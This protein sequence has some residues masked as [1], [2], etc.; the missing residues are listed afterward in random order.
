MPI[1]Q[2]IPRCQ[3]V[4]TNG[5]RCGSPSLANRV[6]CYYHFKASCPPPVSCEIT[7]VETADGIQIAIGN[8]LQA[9]DNDRIDIKKAVAMLYGLQTASSNLKRTNPQPAWDEVETEMPSFEQEVWHKNIATTRAEALLEHDI[10]QRIKDDRQRRKQQK[11]DDAFAASLTPDD[12]DRMAYS[13]TGNAAALTDLDSKKEKRK[14][15]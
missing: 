2:H 1:P 6:F 14:V 8:V 10:Q 4:R 13:A 7:P 3:Y 11:E 5:V 12:L 15:S 9:L